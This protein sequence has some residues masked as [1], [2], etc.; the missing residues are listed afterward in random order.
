[1][2]GGWNVARPGAGPAVTVPVFVT[3]TVTV[4]GQYVR[5]RDSLVISLRSAGRRRGRPFCT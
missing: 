5:S 4:L 1:M 2:E 3:N